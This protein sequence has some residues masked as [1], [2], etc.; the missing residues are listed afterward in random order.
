MV[1]PIVEGDE[2][3]EILLLNESVKNISPLYK[4]N[5][6]YFNINKN[7]L[8]ELTKQQEKYLNYLQSPQI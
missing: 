1:F 4:L 5:E 6:K 2:S 7:K 8:L 3:G